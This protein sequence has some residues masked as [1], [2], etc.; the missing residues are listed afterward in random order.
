MIPLNSSDNPTNRTKKIKYLDENVGALNVNLSPEE[1]QEIR[2][3]AEE[4]E[5]AG[6]R[7]PA[8][9]LARVF[10]DTPPL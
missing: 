2:Q 9:L 3:L 1:V 7:Y 5:G 8:A 6:D 10:G 4:A